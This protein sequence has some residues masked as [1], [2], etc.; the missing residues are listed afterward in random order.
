MASQ[1]DHY[2]DGSA[3]PPRLRVQHSLWS[4]LKLPMNTP[5]DGRCRRSAGA[6]R[7]PASPASSAGWTRAANSST[8]MPWTPPGCA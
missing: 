4:L 7:K 3:N 2:N 8:R 5:R 1:F 6:S